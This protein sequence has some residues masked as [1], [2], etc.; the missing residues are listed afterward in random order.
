MSR[1]RTRPVHLSA[2][3]LV[4]GLLALSGGQTAAALE[5]LAKPEQGALVRAR[6]PGAVAV[7]VDGVKLPV[8][9]DGMFAFGIGR[10]SAGPVTIEVT[11][12]GSTTPGSAAS[13]SDTPTVER[14]VLDV[15]PRAWDIQR[16][17]GL[18]PAQVTP[19][20]Q[21]LERIAAERKRILAARPPASPFDGVWQAWVWPAE[22]RI[23]GVF[24][25]Q[26]ILNGEP[27]APHLG[28]DIAGPVG[29]P[30]VAP[31]AGRVTLAEPDLFFTGKTVTIDHGHGVTSIFAHLSDATVSVG[32]EVQ[33]GTPIGTIGATGR[34]TG[35]HLHWGVYWRNTAV[36]PRRLL[37]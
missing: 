20:P 10:E 33:Q 7:S 31:A 18:P 25:S 37:P 13:A 26:R 21:A 19:D 14:H 5:L 22:G 1:F 3:I 23:S 29:T 30:V 16:I 2:A 8:T 24:G 32:Q 28:L 4:A 17:E 35:P 12:P 6:A 11:R 27:R 34:V 9:P 36:D 15:A